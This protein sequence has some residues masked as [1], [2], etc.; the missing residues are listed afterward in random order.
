MDAVPSNRHGDDHHQVGKV[1]GNSFYSI[2]AQQTQPVK[3]DVDF[4]GVRTLM[5]SVCK[6]QAS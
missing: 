5:V 1:S 2:F 4:T 6:R 3:N